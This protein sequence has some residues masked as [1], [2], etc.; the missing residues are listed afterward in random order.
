MHA[1]RNASA[2]SPPLPR[3]AFRSGAVMGFLLSAL[4]LLNLYLTII[5]F[6]H[7]SWLRCAARRAAPARA[8]VL[9]LT[10]A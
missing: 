6:S 3:A 5:V 7:V 8:R 4:G 10:A 2:C 1:A 9:L